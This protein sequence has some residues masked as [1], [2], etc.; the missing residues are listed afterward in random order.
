VS[1]LVYRANAASKVQGAHFQT[2]FGGKVLTAL[3]ILNFPEKTVGHTEDWASP[4]DQ[5]AWFANVSG[6]ILG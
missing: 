4:K 3:P 2:F 6:A 1:R 5:R